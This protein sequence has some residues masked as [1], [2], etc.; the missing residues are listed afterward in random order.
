MLRSLGALSGGLV[1]EVGAVAIPARL[2]RTSLYRTAVEVALRFLIQQ[3]GQVENVYSAEGQLAENFLLQRG[4]SHGIEILGLL[5]LH[6]SPI[7]IL[8]AL[9]DAA[10]AGGELIGEISQALKREGLLDPNAHFETVDQLLDGLEKTSAHLADTLNTP[11]LN[12][13]GLR[14]DWQKLKA[15]LPALPR[16]ALPSPTMLSGLWNEL[17]QSA[18]IQHRSVF[19]V[20]SAIALSTVA[21]VPDNLLWL[22]R[23]AR[24]AAVR[25]GSVLGEGLFDHYKSALTE[26]SACGFLPYWQRQFSPYLSAAAQHFAAARPSTTE[27]WIAKRNRG[28]PSRTADANALYGHQNEAMSTATSGLA[29]V[30]QSLVDLV[31]RSVSGVVAVK[32]APYRVVSGICV[33]DDVFAVADHSLRREDRVPV[34]AANGAHAFA[35]ILGR[36]PGLDLAFLK[37]DGLGISPLPPADSASLKPGSLAIVVGLT[38]D[39]GPSTSLGILGAVGGSRRTWRGATLDHFYRLDI[40]LYPSQAGAAVVNHNGELI[41][42]ATPALLRH[43]T[44][45]IPIPTIHRVLDELLKTGRIREGY[46]GVGIQPIPIPVGLRTKTGYNSESGLIVL[47]VV[48]GTPADESGVQLGD[49]LI[50]LEGKPV[51]DVDELQGAL[52]G[53]NVDR[54]LKALFI[55]GGETIETQLKVAE[56]PRKA[57]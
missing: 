51:S 57:N 23:A 34:H 32:A 21:K 10:G 35:T 40:N 6:V 25:T 31:G 8:A 14:R 12:I 9:S 42:L 33:R 48:P 46:L 52:R 18:E 20:C 4:A 39:V 30:S 43:S 26:I 28:E 49:I 37:A 16:A 44:V 41:G 27:K 50:A 45:A 15:E 56:R 7:W 13:A 29:A 5:T 24:V 53:E 3:L 47:N 36:D 19:A 17:K 2:R 54:S 1:R 22:S 38:L 55:R 11:P